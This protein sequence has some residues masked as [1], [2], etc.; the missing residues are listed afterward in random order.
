VIQ[1]RISDIIV[2]DCLSL[3]HTHWHSHTDTHTHKQ[4]RKPQS[5]DYRLGL[6]DE[7]RVGLRHC[8][9]PAWTNLY[10]YW[11]VCESVYKEK[12][13]LKLCIYGEIIHTQHEARYYVSYITHSSNN[14]FHHAL[15]DYPSSEWR[16]QDVVIVLCNVR[17][18]LVTYT[19]IHTTYAISSARYIQGD[20]PSCC[21]SWR[22]AS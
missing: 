9:T 13:L 15:E 6:R 11:Y 21:R 3:T 1:C 20:G 14:L 8:T 16:A 2:W 19:Y 7:R 17:V 22:R 12:I 18:P 5:H 10:R 4:T